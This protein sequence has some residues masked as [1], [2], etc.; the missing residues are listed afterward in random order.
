MGDDARVS[1]SSEVRP[2]AE[3]GTDTSW[4]RAVAEDAARFDRSSSA[5]RVADVLRRRITEGALPPGTQ[6]SEEV[7]KVALQ[8]SRN[9]L[10]EAFRLLTHEGLLVHKLH[11]GVF[12]PDL[13]EADAVDLYRLRR[14]LECDVVRSLRG[15]DPTRLEPLRDD[16]EASEIAALA[17]DWLAVGT[18]NMR[19]HQHLVGLANSTRLDEIAGRLLAEVRLLFHVI[20]TPRALHEPYIARNRALLELL[21]EGEYEQAADQLHQYMLDSEAGLLVAFRARG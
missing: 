2:A 21:E 4:L 3:P 9:T 6:L 8:V 19:F 17:G 7:L 18:A 16:V 10:R 5:E 1:S 15:L 12:V 14:V 13:T 11:R 20:A